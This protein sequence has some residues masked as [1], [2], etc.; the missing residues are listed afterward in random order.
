M[1]SLNTRITLK[2]M[3]NL[4]VTEM[5]VYCTKILNWSS[6][7]SRFSFR[8]EFILCENPMSKKCVA[9]PPVDLPLLLRVG[10]LSCL[11]LSIPITLS[12]WP[13]NY[14]SSNT[15]QYFKLKHFVAHL[16]L[17]YH[18]QQKIHHHHNHHHQVPIKNYY[19]PIPAWEHTHTQH[20]ILRTR[21][22][23]WY[24][25]NMHEYNMV[26]QRKYGMYFLNAMSLSLASHGLSLIQNK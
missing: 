17:C 4:R 25:Y 16:S 10:P 5:V 1:E 23:L 3:L 2:N 11:R 12:L 14:D 24:Y 18:Y 22:H 13:T 8:Y 26:V 7:I 20:L 15:K 19:W 6:S 9:P 21:K